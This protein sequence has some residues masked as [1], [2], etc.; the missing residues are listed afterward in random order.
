VGADAARI[1]ETCAEPTLRLTHAGTLLAQAGLS[2]L[3]HAWQSPLNW[4]RQR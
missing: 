1:G 2:A 4:G 3:R